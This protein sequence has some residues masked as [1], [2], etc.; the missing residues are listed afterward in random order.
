MNRQDTRG[1]K[2]LL[3]LA[4]GLTLMGTFSAAMTLAVFSD[5]ET[6]TGTF[7][8]GSIILDDVKVDGLTLS[9][10]AI[11]PGDSITDDVVIE[12]D[13]TAQLRYAISTSTT[14]PDTKALRDALTLT[15][16]TVDA[17]TPGTPC[18]NF[19]GTSL[20]AGVLGA[21]TAAVGSPAAGAQAGDRVLNSLTSETLCFRLELPIGTGNAYAAASAVTT[22]TFDAEQTVNN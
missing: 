19:D 16:K 13:G 14:N 2:R 15:I 8:S 22:F 17:T 5:Q 20:Y 21:A 18:D 6:V 7:S 4:V 11:M 9:V 10:S 3:G 12:N 1:R